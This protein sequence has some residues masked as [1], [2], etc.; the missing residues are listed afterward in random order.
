MKNQ[1]FADVND[2]FKY[3]LCI[4]LAENLPG[5][6]RFTFIPTLTANDGKKDGNKVVY[7]MGVGQES[8]YKFLKGCLQKNQREVVHLWDYFKGQDFKFDYCPYADSLDKEFTHSNREEYFQN[9]PDEDLQS[10][11]IMVDPD[12]GLEVKAARPGNFH[13]Y[14]K[15]SEA[16]QLY[17]RMDANSVLIIYQHFPFIERRFFLEGLHARILEELN[18]P[19]PMT[20]FSSNIAMVMLAK[21]AAARKRLH[22]QV[23]RYLRRELKLHE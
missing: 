21:N 3:D 23:S 17:G 20:V 11:V 14:I 10:A 9:I 4:F 13:K 19:A 2:Y 6:Q 16:R 22:K 15:Y 1:Y 18:C 12:N 5:I 8:L 7:P